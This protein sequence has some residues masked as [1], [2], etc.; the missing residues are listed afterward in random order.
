MKLLCLACLLLSLCGC[1]AVQEKSPPP[2]IREP[3][4]DTRPCHIETSKTTPGLQVWQT[5][6]NDT[7]IIHVKNN[8]KRGMHQIQ[9][10]HTRGTLPPK[11]IIRIYQNTIRTFS[12]KN[13][14]LYQHVNRPE[15]MQS[16][17][18]SYDQNRRSECILDINNGYWILPM[19]NYHAQ[20]GKFT[21]FLLGDDLRLYLS[22]YLV[23][24]KMPSTIT[25]QWTGDNSNIKK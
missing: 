1:V 11:T 6:E 23:K 25:I 2:T 22:R 18:L 7:L 4:L 16:L 5:T 10:L 13:Q 20:H 15:D 9:L 17:R 21:D 14:R 19:D 8:I 3:E 24:S 12:V